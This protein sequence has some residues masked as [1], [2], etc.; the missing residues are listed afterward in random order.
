ML[1]WT[2]QRKSNSLW[3]EGIKAAASQLWRLNVRKPQ[4]NWWCNLGGWRGNGPSDF[5]PPLSARVHTARSAMHQFESIYLLSFSIYFWL[6]IPSQSIRSWSRLNERKSFE[7]TRFK[8]AKIFLH[9]WHTSTCLSSYLSIL[10]TSVHSF[11]WIVAWKQ[12]SAVY[13]ECNENGTVIWPFVKL[14]ILTVQY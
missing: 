4:T 2:E 12:S 9:D 13:W 1:I 3:C 8:C 7:F 5:L 6:V 10:H 11:I 14:L